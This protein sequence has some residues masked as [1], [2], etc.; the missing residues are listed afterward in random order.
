MAPGYIKNI[1]LDEPCGHSVVSSI[2]S[3]APFFIQNDL[4][5]VV[6]VTSPSMWNCEDLELFDL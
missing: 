1:V 3:L 4:L 5:T 2:V 6:L